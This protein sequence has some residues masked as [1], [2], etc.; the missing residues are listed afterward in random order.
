[1]SWR[2]RKSI[3]NSLFRVN[4][5]GNGISSYSF[6]PR[7]ASTN[8]GRRGVSQTFS[9]RGTGL[10]YRRQLTR[11]RPERQQQQGH[12]IA[13]AAGWT[14]GSLISRALFGGFGR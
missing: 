8:V 10:S 4:V 1:M 7:G 11:I 2:F 12:P 14:I 13:A 5:T 6:G 9:I 3:G